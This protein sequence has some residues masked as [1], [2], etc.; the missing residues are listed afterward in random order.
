MQETL[1]TCLF[2][3]GCLLCFGAAVPCFSF[4]PAPVPPL[5]PTSLLQGAL[6]PGMTAPWST[7]AVEEVQHL[8]GAQG[9]LAQHPPAGTPRALGGGTGSSRCGDDLN[10]L[11]PEV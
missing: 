9:S 3:Q 5:I 2:L 8:P 11:N 6:S 7:L 1:P 10:F 4:I